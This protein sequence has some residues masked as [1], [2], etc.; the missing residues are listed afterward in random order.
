MPPYQKKL[1]RRDFLKVSLIAASSP[2]LFSACESKE[3]RGLSRANPGVTPAQLKIVEFYSQAFILGPPPSKELLAF[4]VHLYTPEEAEVVQHLPLI[5][6]RT[7]RAISPKIKR[8]ENEVEIILS[9]IADEKRAILAFGEPGKPRKY[10]LMPLVPG[11]MEL[12]MMEGKNDDWH[13]RYGQLFEAVY[14]TGYIKDVLKKRIPA[15]RYIPVQETINAIPTALSTDRLTQMME[16]NKS[17]GLGT[18][19]CRQA[20]AFSGHDC[21]L[22]R[23]T[24]LATGSLADFLISRNIM[25]RV[26]RSEALESKL[27]ANA[28]GLATMSMN[29]EFR[30]PNISCSCCGCCCV[31]LRTISQFN[32]PGLIAPPHFIPKRDESKCLKCGLCQSKCPMGSHFLSEK[33]WAFRRERCIGCGVCASVCPAR[34]L[35]MEPVEHYHRPPANYFGLGLKMTPGYLYYLLS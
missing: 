6:G 23:D 1:D 32:T 4:V 34:A 5:Y 15:T 3:I 31:I 25:R 27:K 35:A 20:K 8:P 28:A 11:T 13:R 9:R 19:Q 14:E 10:G 18:C 26:D 24:C 33:G 21:G 29:V 2:A 16:E 30:E 12:V 17:F 7:A 22:P